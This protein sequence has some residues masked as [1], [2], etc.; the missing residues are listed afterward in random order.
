MSSEIIP[1]G[2]VLIHRS[3]FS[4]WLWEPRKLS[5]W[6]AWIWIIARANYEEK[7]MLSGN[8]LVNVNRGELITS[9]HKLESTFKWSQHEVRAFLS[10]LEKDKMIIKI[11]T[12][13][14][15]RLTVCNYEDYQDILQAKHKQAASKKQ[16]DSKQ[17]S[18]K[19]QRHKEVKAENEIK[20]VKAEYSFEIFWTLYDKKV[21]KHKCELKWAKISDADKEVIIQRVPEY[22]KATAAEPKYRKNPQTY[23]NGRC[24]EDEHIE[25]K[26]KESS[27]DAIKNGNYILNNT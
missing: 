23:L 26:G 10:L 25:T 18:I 16:T 11:G 14:F 17:T 5:K 12:G 7:P 27:W 8:E 13:K 20:E 4:H 9:I 3:S 22:V 21:D 24:W 15:T 1:I 6:E 19:P 2:Y